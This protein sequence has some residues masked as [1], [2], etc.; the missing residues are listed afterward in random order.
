MSAP[1]MSDVFA[2]AIAQTLPPAVPYG[3]GGIWLKGSSSHP[4]GLVDCSGLWYGIGVALG[5]PV[6]R[7]SEDQ[8]KLLRPVSSPVLGTLIFYDVE[9][10]DQE[11]PAHV[12]MYWGPGHVLQAPRTGENVGI[13]PS[14]PYPIMGYR[15]LPF[16]SSPAP[17][18]AP[19]PSPSPQPQEE[20]MAGPAISADG[21]TVAMV[22][23]DGHLIVAKGGP[24]PAD[25]NNA[26]LTDLT[27]RG[28][29]TDPGAGDWKF[30]TA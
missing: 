18:A 22:R 9:A 3:F 28:V 23:D 11:Q 30:P 2:L 16:P 15:A 14:L 27:D 10:D 1:T 6:P 26:S 25:W 8:F 13:Y 24:T 4:G 19:S 5:V 7:T 21:S 29:A 17:P 12:A 20:D